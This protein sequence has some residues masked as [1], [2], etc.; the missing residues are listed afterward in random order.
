MAVQAY[1]RALAGTQ[2]PVPMLT[3]VSGV[4]QLDADGGDGGLNEQL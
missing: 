3:T 4:R 1:R 2:P